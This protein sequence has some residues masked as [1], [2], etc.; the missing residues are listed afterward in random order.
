MCRGFIK[1]RDWYDFNWYV[2][3]QIS[4]NLLHLQ[5]TLI[6]FG[7]WAND[8]D[9]VVDL[10][11]LKETLKNKI[12]TINW[13]DTADDVERFLTT[14]EQQSLRL[15]SDRFFSSKVDRLDTILYTQP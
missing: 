3:Q 1:G 2:K 9:L 5:N 14:T 11:W 12:T 10:I 7:P 13:R 4:P 6:Q 8:K 15:W